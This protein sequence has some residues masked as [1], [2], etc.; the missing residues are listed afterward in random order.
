MSAVDALAAAPSQPREHLN[1]IYSDEG[2]RYK[3]SL[4]T[5]IGR[6][7]IG[8]VKQCLAAASSC[9]IPLQDMV[10]HLNGVPLSND[11]DLCSSLGIGNGATLSVEPRHPPRQCNGG[12]GDGDGGAWQRHSPRMRGARG[13]QSPVGAAVAGSPASSSLSSPFPMSRQRRLLELQTLQQQD[14]MLRKDDVVRDDVLRHTMRHVEEEMDQANLRRR[15]LQRQRESAEEELQ[16]MNEKEAE[17]AR[18]RER[19]AVLRAQEAARA[20]ER[21][22]KLVERREQLRAEQEAAR[23][24]AILKLENEKKKA[25]LAQQQAFFDAE[26]ERAQLEQ[27]NFEATTKARE[28]EL[29]AREIDIEHLRL[30]RIREAR[31]LDM[32]RRLAVKQR[33][34]YYAQLGVEA[35]RAL[36]R[37]AAAL[38][39]TEEGEIDDNA[40]DEVP[41]GDGSSH[42]PSAQRHG[43]N[44]KMSVTGFK[45][46]TRKSVA[47]AQDTSNN[48]LVRSRGPSSSPLS[49]AGHSVAAVATVPD[50]GFYDARENAEE[51][52]RR[53]G[54]DLGLRDGLQFDDSNTCVISVDGEYTLL[55]MY[56]AAT[57][58]LYL[59]STLLASLPP[60]VQATTEGRL[61]LYEFLLEASLL[62]REMCGGGVGASLRNDFVLM[63]ASLYMPTSQ[64]WS[65]RTLAPQFL[66]C[67]RHWRT[68]LTEFLQTLEAQE[69]HGQSGGTGAVPA[70]PPAAARQPPQHHVY[71]S[72]AS[73]LSPSMARSAP[74]AGSA[75]TSIASPHPKSSAASPSPLQASNTAVVAATPL[76]APYTSSF[77]GSA[78]RVIPVL[79]LE[80]TGTVLVN[81]VPTHYQDGVLVVNAAGPSVLAGVQPN[82]LIEELNGTRVRNVGDFRRVIEEQLTPGMLV[83]EVDVVSA[84]TCASSPEA[85][86]EQPRH[87]AP[88]QQRPGRLQRASRR[89][90]RSRS[91]S[92]PELSLPTPPPQHL[93][94]RAHAR[95]ER[96]NEDARSTG[97]SL[98]SVTAVGS[99][100]RSSNM[101]DGMRVS[102]PL[103]TTAA[104]GSSGAAS[105]DDEERRAEH[106]SELSWNPRARAHPLNGATHHGGNAKLKRCLGYRPWSAS[107]GRPPPAS[108]QQQP[109]RTS[110]RGARPYTYDIPATLASLLCRYLSR[111]PP[112]SP[113]AAAAGVPMPEDGTACTHF[114]SVRWGC[115]EVTAPHHVINKHDADKEQRGS[116]SGC[117][118]TSCHVPHRSQ[119]QEH[120][121]NLLTHYP[122]DASACLA[123]GLSVCAALDAMRAAPPPV[124]PVAVLQDIAA[125]TATEVCFFVHA[126]EEAWQTPEK[127]SSEP[128][129]APP[130]LARSV[131]DSTC[132]CGCLA[133]GQ[134][135]DPALYRFHLLYYR[136]HHRYAPLRRGDGGEGQAGESAM[137]DAHNDGERNALEEARAAVFGHP[138]PQR[139]PPRHPRFVGVSNARRSSAMSRQRRRWGLR[140][141]R[142]RSTATAAPPLPGADSANAA[143]LDKQ[144]ISRPSTTQPSQTAKGKDDE[145]E[146]DPVS[147]Y[148]HFCDE[149]ERLWAVMASVLLAWKQLEQCVSLTVLVPRLEVLP[150]SS[151]HT[152]Q[153]A[154]QSTSLHVSRSSALSPLARAAAS[155]RLHRT[156]VEGMLLHAAF[157]R[158]ALARLRVRL[159][160][161]PPRPRDTSEA[162]LS[163]DVASS[164]LMMESFLCSE[165]Q[166]RIAH[167]PLW[168]A[169]AVEV[170]QLYVEQSRHDRALRERRAQEENDGTAVPGAAGRN[171]HAAWGFV[172]SGRVQQVVLLATR[173]MT[174]PCVFANDASTPALAAARAEAPP[175][176]PCRTCRWHRASLANHAARAVRECGDSQ[177]ASHDFQAT[178]A[179]PASPAG[180]KVA[181]PVSAAT[182]TQLSEVMSRHPLFGV[183]VAVVGG[184]VPLHW[185]EA[186]V[187]PRAMN[188]H[189]LATVPLPPLPAQINSRSGDGVDAWR[190]PV[191]AMVAAD[192]EAQ[193]ELRRLVQLLHKWLR[194]AERRP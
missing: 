91:A 21:A 189:S 131:D 39:L 127:A 51:N 78:K 168:C 80:V 185:A 82:D 149:T 137:S 7:T 95:H 183:A 30:A 40:E 143:S 175:P 74:H 170:L 55:V 165:L 31:A 188:V 154:P 48:D 43:L 132:T 49:H 60:V 19:L 89:R 173:I 45:S 122:R 22:A 10:L 72:A 12:E 29:R 69:G 166:G 103:V 46:H 11:K 90:W 181:V 23:A 118:V 160:S 101:L 128:T 52:L 141:T 102:P 140:E 53:L 176:P 108:P 116:S 121:W 92:A 81:G 110:L 109:L 50:G 76:A 75:A 179:T 190:T 169:V 112:L 97:V 58:R 37:E 134:L 38:L 14:E 41:A 18:E 159:L 148:A 151:L 172:Y 107:D 193:T 36:Q 186:C 3:L 94:T 33:L 63:S 27:E 15:Q 57:E 123:L 104:H 59:Y 71:T 178:A 164:L 84:T 182:V 161:L 17:A 79:G 113:A 114:L 167:L 4:R 61:K 187:A 35:P 139:Q 13:T 67:L 87:V 135:L 105:A 8:K 24:V 150:S 42:W 98:S 88:P 64:P 115:V 117:S 194:E 85:A 133:A 129:A 5:P 25:L 120:L 86:L 147:N 16:R 146:A 144:A 158:A 177:H 83:P 156:T 162:N 99:R 100:S 65:L 77:G 93:F 6:L 125:T 153:F 44:S 56:D 130:P 20:T 155:M 9:P 32:D 47:S 126:C 157:E 163:D 2:K 34:H 70:T 66:H 171:D 180:A 54:D 111:T 152:R 119:Q 26:R 145:A 192:A 174:L 184:G 73:S 138:H 28:L 96:A 191:A 62:G 106:A 1:I 142:R 124:L 136:H 68:K